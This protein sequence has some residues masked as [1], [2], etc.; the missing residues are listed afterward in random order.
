MKVS[1]FARKVYRTVCSIPLGEVRTYQWVARKAGNPRAVR[2][3]GQLM[4]RNPFPVLIP[5]HR[6]V[7][8]NGRPG[9][10]VFGIEKKKRLLAYEQE[11]K[12]CLARRK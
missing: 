9:G 4:K 8:S 2:A 5:C 10:Y 7:G 11:I 1:A 3:V 6:V 12:Q